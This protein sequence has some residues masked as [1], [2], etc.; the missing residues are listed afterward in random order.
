MHSFVFSFLLHIQCRKR[1]VNLDDSRT[2]S[3]HFY[4]FVFLFVSLAF[5]RIE[6]KK[7]IAETRRREKIRKEIEHE[8]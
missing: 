2:C 1:V 7:A 3:I 4:N 8:T 5:T 6:G